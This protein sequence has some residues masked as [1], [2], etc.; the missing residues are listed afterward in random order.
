MPWVHYITAKDVICLANII[1]PASKSLTVTDRYPD[2]G[3]DAN[4]IKVGYDRKYAYYSY[5]FFDISSIP[6]NAAVQNAELVLFKIDNFYEDRD[7]DFYIY[8]LYDYFSPFTDYNNR[9]SI[10]R[11][12]KKTFYPITAKAA[13]TVDLT[14]I[15]S[16]WV[17][18]ELPA[19]GIALLKKDNACCAGFGSSSCINS[20]LSPF[21][22]VIF[23][24]CACNKGCEKQYNNCNQNCV[25]NFYIN[26]IPISC[27]SKPTI[28]KVRVIGTVGPRSKYVAVIDVK[29]TREHSKDTNDYYAADE[30][31]N[32]LSDNPL[33]IDKTYDIVI[34]PHE[35]EGD[36]EEV[37]LY[38]SYKCG[39]SPSRL[40]TA[41]AK[42]SD[43]QPIG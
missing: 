12:M 32:S 31:D 14:E 18:N 8:P 37:N 17:E 38:G 23:T 40:Q 1:I 25:Q 34:Y 7:M 24:Q 13:V 22:R 39:G 43:G 9:P 19:A 11:R 26:C 42:A 20:C 29:V 27:S 3:I 15:V 28:R 2:T 21:I 16:M 36:T 30:Y 35:N 4:T 33:S 5:L 6:T 41:N 10:N